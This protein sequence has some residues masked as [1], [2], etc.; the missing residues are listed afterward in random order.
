MR[1]GRP[2]LPL[3]PT[4]RHPADISAARNLNSLNH[5]HPCI[6]FCTYI[7]VLNMFVQQHY[8]KIAVMFLQEHST[9]G[10]RPKAARCP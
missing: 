2:F 8:V 4:H 1:L 10:H 3:L 6:S 7:I 9:L 5:L